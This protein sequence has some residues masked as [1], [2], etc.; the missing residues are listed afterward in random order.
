MALF[1]LTCCL[2]ALSSSA[3]GR[4]TYGGS[5]SGPAVLRDLSSQQ[6]LVG[7]LQNQNGYGQSNLALTSVTAPRVLQSSGYG[8]QLSRPVGLVQTE[9]TLL[10]PTGYGG[11]VAV[12]VQPIR[13]Q[14][15]QQQLL[16]DQQQLL[17]QRIAES[18]IT[19]EADI[20][21]RGQLP[22]TV[23]PLD[24]GRRFV[25][26]LDN[27]K[28]EEQQCPQGL[29][30][31]QETRR[32]ER[33][34][35]PLPNPCES[36]PC[37]N[38]GQCVLLDAST[39]E[40][41]CQPGFDGKTCELDARVCQTQK[42]GGQS[43]D[44]KCQSFRWGAALSHM[45]VFQGGLGYGFN[46]QQIHPNPCQGAKGPQPLANSDK[47]FLLCD[48]EAMSPESCPGGTVWDDLTK[49]CV[50]PDM[51][52]VAVVS[53]AE[54]PHVARV[55][56]HHHHQHRTLNLQQPGYGASLAV[57]SYGQQQQQPLSQYGQQGQGQSLGQLQQQEQQQQLQQQQQQQRLPSQY[58]QQGQAQLFGSSQNGQQGQGQS[59]GS[60]QNGQ[61]GLGQSFGSSQNGQ[62]GQGQ[63][64][65]SLQNGQQGQGQQF[66]SSQNGQQGQG[67]PFGSSL[68][69]QQGQG[70]S[71][72]S[73]QQ[74]QEQQQ[75]QQQFQQQQQSPQHR[76]HHQGGLQ[77]GNNQGNRFLQQ[78]QGF[79]Q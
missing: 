31:N 54:Q 19:T 35:G 7:Q 75:Q 26:C 61:Q 62:Q 9:Q 32:C 68:N 50:W 27:G 48:G 15:S 17:Q 79:Q 51:Q 22:E 71:F 41:R 72:G 49:A 58:G 73:S 47:G 60:S 39:H 13:Q 59:F 42:P 1:A 16:L 77:Q 24:N 20:L 10:T 40:C 28:G 12:N 46:T 8:S 34:L 78:Q 38:G 53:Y 23:I 18:Q 21:C 3:F 11:G 43:P 5:L 25:A 67:Q 36:Q 56:G 14:P 6:T 33:T 70:Q 55:L 52:A 63:Q 66:G 76:H 45:C 69:G 74:E 37:L 44:T 57:Q 30:Y 2:L 64:F 4:S 65:G 29:R